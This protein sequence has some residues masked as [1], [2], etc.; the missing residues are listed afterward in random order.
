[1]EINGPVLL[2]QREGVALLTLNRPPAN[3][4]NLQAFIELEQL[5][6]TLARD[7]P[8]QTTRLAVSLSPMRGAG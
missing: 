5:L 8:S 1:M 7:R 2:E 6:D 4:M 3:S